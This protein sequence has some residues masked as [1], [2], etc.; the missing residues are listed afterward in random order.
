MINLLR[1]KKKKIIFIIAVM[2][3]LIITYLEYFSI[4]L[5]SCKKELAISDVIGKTEWRFDAEQVVDDNFD[6]LFFLLIQ[7]FGEKDI[8]YYLFFIEKIE[9]LVKKQG[10]DSQIYKYFS[11]K[12]VCPRDLFLAIFKIIDHYCPKTDFR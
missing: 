11:G 9:E 10:K 2:I 7:Y 1:Q 3:P 12:I 5:N 4:V 6:Y 8:K